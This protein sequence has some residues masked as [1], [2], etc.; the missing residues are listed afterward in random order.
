VQESAK[1]E[2]CIVGLTDC[3]A[4]SPNMVAGLI[5]VGLA[6][7]KTG[8]TSANAQSSRSHAL[9]EISL[10]AAHD[11]TKRVGKLTL[12]DLAGS[13]RGADR[14]D[15]D[16]RTR[17]EGA[18]INKS[19]LAL[20]ECIRALY[21]G[22]VQH[23]P[24]RGSRLTHIMRDAFVGKN[25]HTIVVA[26]VSPASHSAEHTLNTLRY[27]SR[28]K[29]KNNSGAAGSDKALNGGVGLQRKP[30]QRVRANSICEDPRLIQGNLQK[31]RRSVL[32]DYPS[33]PASRS[34]GSGSSAGA[35]DFGDVL[36]SSD[37][38]G[39]QTERSGGSSLQTPPTPMRPAAVNALLNLK[40]KNN[41][42]KPSKRA[43]GKPKVKQLPIWNYDA[44]DAL[45]A[46]WVAGEEPPTA[47]TIE[48]K[49]PNEEAAGDK[50]REPLVRAFGQTVETKAI[51]V[52]DESLASRMH[53]EKATVELHAECCAGLD[54]LRNEDQSL[55]GWAL[56][57]QQNGELDAGEYMTRLEGILGQRAAVD[58]KLQEQLLLLKGQVEREEKAEAELENL[59][60]H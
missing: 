12:V 34:E 31:E 42:S 3:R 58:K 28:I 37:S 2:V 33:S 18:E 25:S 60:S 11:P 30:L 17:R 43:K 48:K 38:S 32:G 29:E 14:G 5:D 23:V 20:K 21:S 54:R 27:A 52:H 57:T 8:S 46:N 45:D 55:I 36:G 4:E 47:K 16:S 10:H 41:K 35:A 6:S 49:H 53:T 19:L 26:C 51:Q 15:T 56:A 7:R 1:G 50:P 39:S 22:A 13:E 24:F 40:Y 9:F 59:L 44:A